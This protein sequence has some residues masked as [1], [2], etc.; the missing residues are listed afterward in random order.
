[1]NCC[2]DPMAMGRVVCPKPRRVGPYNLNSSIMP[3]RFRIR[4]DVEVSDSI[5]GDELLDLILRKDYK[6]EQCAALPSSPPF[7][8]GSPPCRAANPVVQ[9]SHFR[10]EPRAS[11]C[12]SPSNPALSSSAHPK[13][14]FE[15]KQA[16]IRVEGF[17]CQSS[18]VAMA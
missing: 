11:N 9:D 7:F 2:E 13:V 10:V 1:M 14:G 4:N 17:D 12:F 3:L 18:R 5:T 8:F 16:A 15:K 6:A